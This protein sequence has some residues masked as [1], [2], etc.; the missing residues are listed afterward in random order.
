LARKQATGARDRHGVLTH[1]LVRHTAATSRPPARCHRPRTNLAP[2][3]PTSPGPHRRTLAMA[4]AAFDGLGGRTVDEHLVILQTLLEDEA[5]YQP[6]RNY[7][8]E[9]DSVLQ[10]WMRRDV[11]DWLVEVREWLRPA[12]IWRV[13][14]D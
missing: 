1:A 3:D 14:H 9:G 12:F 5:T 2:N 7:V 10:P 11:V 13:C 4:V 6:V 8:A